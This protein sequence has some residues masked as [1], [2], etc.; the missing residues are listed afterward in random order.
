MCSTPSPILQKFD[1]KICQCIVY[2]TCAYPAKVWFD[3]KICQCLVY[4]TFAYPAK[5]VWLKV[6]HLRLSYKSLTARYVNVLCTTPAPIL[7][8]FDLI[9]RY[10]N[11]LCTIPSPIL[12]RMSDLKYYTFAY[13]AK[14]WLK[15]MSI[16]S[17]LHLRLS[18]KGGLT[19]KNV[20]GLTWRYVNVLCTTPSPILQRRFNLKICQC[21]VYYTFAYPAKEV[22][23]TKMSKAWLEDMSMSCVLHLRLSCKRGLTC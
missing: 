4:Y 20:K 8:R 19:Y 9:W 7:Q 22:W 16:S 11:V 5:D 6:L 3:L 1:C 15:D 2:Y 17:V 10:V 13:P 12:Q 18:C 23:L 14:V 21:L